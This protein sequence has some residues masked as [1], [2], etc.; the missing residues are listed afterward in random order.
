[1]GKTFDPATVLTMPIP[2]LGT[3]EGYFIASD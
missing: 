1:M 3:F 2:E